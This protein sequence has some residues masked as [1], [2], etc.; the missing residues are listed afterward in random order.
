LLFLLCIMD[1]DLP[2]LLSCPFICFSDFIPM[3]YL[4]FVDFHVNGNDN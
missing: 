2:A 1:T 4:V 3:V